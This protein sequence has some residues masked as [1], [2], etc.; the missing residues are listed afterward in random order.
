MYFW[1]FAELALDMY[2]CLEH[3][4]RLKQRFNEGKRLRVKF[5]FRLE[6]DLPEGGEASEDRL[7]V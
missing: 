4:V 7:T 1:K 2:F 3:K 5:T 6:S